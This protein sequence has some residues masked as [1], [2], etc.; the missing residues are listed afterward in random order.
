M[1]PKVEKESH[2]NPW[3]NVK[4]TGLLGGAKSDFRQ[5]LSGRHNVDPGIG[6]E[7]QIALAGDVDVHA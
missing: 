5:I 7:V 4:V 6:Q 3:F 1:L 2:T